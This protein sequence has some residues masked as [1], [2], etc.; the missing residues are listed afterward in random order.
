MMLDAIVKTFMTRGNRR[1]CN[2][3]QRG[4]ANLIEK[5]GNGELPP[6]REKARIREQ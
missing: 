3:N 6:F 1:Q 5:A 2:S 4:F